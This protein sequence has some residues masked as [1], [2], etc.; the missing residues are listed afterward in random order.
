M[1][2]STNLFHSQGLQSIQKHQ[3][4]VL[5]M[6][7]KLSTGKRINAPGDDPVAL[8]Q[9]HSLNRTMSNIDQYATN[10]EFAKS[11][12]SLEETAVTDVINN[13]Q[14]ARELTIQMMNGTYNEND[15][16]A[17][18]AEINQ[19]IQQIS[20]QM[21]IANS[22]G[23]K[24]FAGNNVD[25]E[26][27][28]VDDVANP[29]YKSYIGHINA[30]SDL[31]VDALYSVANQYDELANYGS[32]SVQ[33]SFD[34]DNKV[35]ASNSNDISRVKISDNGSSVFTIPD[36]VTQFKTAL[37]YVENIEND[38]AV[39]AAKFQFYPM[40]DGQSI[41]ISGLTYTA[42]TQ[43][44][45]DEVAV[46]FSSLADGA[47]MGAGTLTGS[48]SGTLAD[49]AS[50]PSLNGNELVFT[51][52]TGVIGE[53]VADIAV[54]KT[55][56]YPPELNILNVLIELKRDL[57]NNDVTG[58]SDYAQDMEKAISH[59]SSVRAEI[60]GR[61]NRIETQFDSGESFKLA[62]EER[63]MGIEDMDVVEGITEL[64][65]FQNSLQMA[66]QV[67]ARV[68]DMSLFNYLR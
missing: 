49:W 46:A 13:V 50:G 11:Q 48:Y 54:S 26:F 3:Q 4:D 20:N 51:S 35:L 58:M 40:T 47:T 21:N 38:N 34:P 60:G 28:Y 32:R 45:A 1:R 30:G 27:S 18:S 14:R 65:K 56:V 31:A 68:Q 36:G 16:A 59:M 62:L 15:R 17:T 23:E 22:E 5:D 10:G 25:A 63:R 8:N 43:M 42:N 52:T 41:T 67:F 24:L 53:N 6:Q 66:Q 9:I 55:D 29:G 57:D 44:T 64:T 61:Q 33:I 7:L 19:I 39:E 37:P 12:L 2:I